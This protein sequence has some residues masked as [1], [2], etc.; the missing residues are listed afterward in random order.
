LS[1]IDANTNVAGDQ[2]FTYIGADDFSGAG[3]LQVLTTGSLN[4]LIRGDIDG[5]GAADLLIK[6]AGNPGLGASSFVL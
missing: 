1:T 3:Q 4:T 6:L 2:A 5:D